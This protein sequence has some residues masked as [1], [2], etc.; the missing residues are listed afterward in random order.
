V[1]AIYH[2]IDR[3]TSSE[4]LAQLAMLRANNEPIY[5]VAPVADDLPF[6]LAG[7][8]RSATVW[9]GGQRSGWPG[10]SQAGS[11]Y[12]AW[13]PRAAEL[14]HRALMH[15]TDRRIVATLPT[16]HEGEPSLWMGHQP[17]PPT[18][19][20]VP[21]ETT[22]QQLQE[23]SQMACEI[24]VI[25]PAAQ[26]LAAGA[27][28]AEI[29]DALHLDDDEVLVV[30]GGTLDRHAGQLEAC[31]AFAI[32][33]MAGMKAQIAVTGDGDGRWVCEKFARG[34]GFIDETHFTHGRWSQNEILAA[35]DVATLL[36]PTD[37]GVQ[38]H[39]QAMRAGLAVLAAETPEVAEFCGER[40]MLSEPGVVRKASSGLLKLCENAACAD[41][42]SADALATTAQQ[43]AEANYTVAAVRQQYETIYSDLR[44]GV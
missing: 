44:G 22:K 15:T 25:P 32:C 38:N 3:K 14:C 19:L 36:S 6:E 17:G 13:S 7:V 39:A 26:A 29:R 1:T 9:D 27:Q 28:R 5:S 41:A 20:V 40:A 16:G 8:I 18:T 33:R 42:A 30:A 2:I 31:W 11:V 23:F 43:Y 34:T 4:Q 10:D 35:G 24:V 12:H 37:R 21:T